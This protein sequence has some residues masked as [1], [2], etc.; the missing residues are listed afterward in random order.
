ME[1]NTRHI[2]RSAKGTIIVKRS[3][4]NLIS[5]DGP[6]ALV[7]EWLKCLDVGELL[8]PLNS[9]RLMVGW[10]N[11]DELWV[12]DEPGAHVLCRAHRASPYVRGKTPDDPPYCT[13]LVKIFGEETW[14]LHKDQ[15]TRFVSDTVQKRFGGGP[16]SMAIERV[17]TETPVCDRSWKQAACD[18]RFLD[19]G[20]TD[21]KCWKCDKVVKTEEETR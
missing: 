11:D 5:V 3:H 12:L 15:I 8:V 20:A 2:I 7:D 9:D 19:D 21:F 17:K 10:P 4:G 16:P 1:D 14:T 18:H 6:D 13:W